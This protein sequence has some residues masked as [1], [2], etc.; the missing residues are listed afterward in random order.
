MRAVRRL[1]CL[2]L[3]LASS[4]PG[5]ARADLTASA[6]LSASEA[7]WY[8]WQILLADSAAVIAGVEATRIGGG[9][10]GGLELASV[11]VYLA[12][13]PL[14]HKA[15]DRGSTAAISLALRFLA[16]PIVGLIGDTVGA[17]LCAPAPNTDVRT[18][19]EVTGGVVGIAIGVAGVSIFDA[20]R[21][22]TRPVPDRGLA[23]APYLTT[24]G[25]GPGTVVGLVGRF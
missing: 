16:V 6:P 3:V 24:S 20:S 8:G 2:I 23:L 13:G 1:L 5:V 15:H 10:S 11:A 14:I 9:G 18:H 12:A 19:C 17:Q 21:S 22:W 7:R 4:W 25:T